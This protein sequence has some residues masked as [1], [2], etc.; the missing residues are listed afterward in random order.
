M[1]EALSHPQTRELLDLICAR[2]RRIFDAGRA[3]EVLTVDNH[4]DGPYIYLK[5]LKEDPR[6][7]RRSWNCSK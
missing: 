2:T 4:A 7:A 1:A 3:A 6:R 5:L